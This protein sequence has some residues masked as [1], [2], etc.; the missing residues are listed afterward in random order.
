MPFQGF[1]YL[2]PADGPPPDR[3]WAGEIR[4]EMGEAANHHFNFGTWKTEETS[5]TGAEKGT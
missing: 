1:L 4:W 5:A 2:C 3:G